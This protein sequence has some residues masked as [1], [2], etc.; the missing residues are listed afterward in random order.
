MIETTETALRQ[1]YPDAI[2]ETGEACGMNR[3]VI[4]REDLAR[5]ARFLKD[6]M[7][8]DYPT[9]LTALDRGDNFELVYNL[10]S[11]SRKEALM[12]KVLVPREDS[13]VVSVIEIWAGVDW[14]EREAFDLMGIQFEGHPDLRRILL[15]EDW[16]GHPL[17]KDYETT[18]K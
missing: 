15:P 10:Y 5:V 16:E 1:Q 7:E 11:T 14:Q 2:V 9:C 17:R 3:I 18:S 13:K 8:F 12:L 4:R 6:R